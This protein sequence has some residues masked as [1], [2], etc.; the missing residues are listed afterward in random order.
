MLLRI[1]T[2]P[3]QGAEY[4]TLLGVARAVETLG[5][6]GF[7]RSDHFMDP[8]ETRMPGPSH[9]W[10]TLAGLARE[11]SRIKLGT[12]MT[13][14]TFQ[15]PGAL[16]VAVAT[17]DRMSQGRVELGLGAGWFQREH[18]AY[19]IPYQSLGERFDRFE[20]Q[21]TIISGLWN[22]PVGKAFS[23]VGKHYQLQDC[24]ALPK[25]YTGRC[26][27]IIGG[28][29]E[30]RTPKVAA[31]FGDEYN[32]NFRSVA[33]TKVAFDRVY[34]ACQAQSRTAPMLYSTAQEVACGR[35]DA[36]VA[37]RA[38]GTKREMAW[39]RENGLV[40]SPAEIVHKIGQFSEIGCSRVYLRILD[41][42]DMDHLELLATEVLPHIPSI[43]PESR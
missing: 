1:F 11:T 27:I 28:A 35:N 14:A 2:E 29:G 33:D 12:L 13:A 18:E 8:A 20:E 42:E 24:P 40:G 7:F 38:A 10:V 22:T 32:I 39:L 19:G 34:A 26:P 25:P 17:V 36:E 15:L 30:K 9:S 3:Q 43:G 23:F 37:R 31:R 4:E 21:L 6:D 41:L 5:F 16:A